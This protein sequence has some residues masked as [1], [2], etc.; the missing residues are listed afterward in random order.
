MSKNDAVIKDLMAKVESQKK[1]MGAKPRVV[2]NTNGLFKKDSSEFFNI[3]TVSD[4][5]VLGSAMGFLL[6]QEE[7]FVKGCKE[8]E[9]SDSVEFKW[10]GY[11]QKTSRGY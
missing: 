5:S 2:W 6:A 1:A 3:N 10:N 7:S 11:S 4:T 9:V 8:I